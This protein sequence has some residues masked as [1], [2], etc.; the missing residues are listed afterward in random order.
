MELK[1]GRLDYWTAK[2][3]LCQKLAIEQLVQGNAEQGLDNLRRMAYALEQA[4]QLQK[5]IGL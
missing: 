5:E 2:A 3:G 1:T 4:I